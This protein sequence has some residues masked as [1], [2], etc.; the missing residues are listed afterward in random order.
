[1]I[2]Y[3]HYLKN[4]LNQLF[5]SSSTNSLLMPTLLAS[6]STKLAEILEISKE[7][8]SPEH[9]HE[10]NVMDTDSGTSFSESDK[11]SDPRFMK[12]S[13]NLLGFTTESMDMPTVD[14]VTV[15][16]IEVGIIEPKFKQTPTPKEEENHEQIKNKDGNNK[17]EEM[18]DDSNN[19]VRINIGSSESSAN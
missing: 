9:P 16:D 17:E 18:T 11:Y 6:V 1:M 12:S 15:G 19:E 5:F 13:E 8:I 4:N 14:H 10:I 7:E 3:L 2:Q